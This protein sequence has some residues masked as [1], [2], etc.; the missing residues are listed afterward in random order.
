MKRTYEWKLTDGRTVTLEAE[1]SEHCE[2]EVL[3]LDGDKWN[4]GK[5]IIRKSGMLTVYLDGKK[6][7]SCWDTNF[8]QVI[9]TGKPGIK[10]IWGIKQ[11]AF[12][13]ERAEEIAKFLADAIEAGRDAE[14]QEIRVAENAAEVAEEIENAEK[15][16]AAAE[17]QKDIPDRAEAKRRMKRWNDV[18]N[19]GGEGYV[20]HIICREEYEH[21]K[22]KLEKLRA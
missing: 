2:D 20:P 10:K 22:Q 18:H 19:E 9:E 21:A 12:T 4:T 16:I 17:A 5:R 7:D 13:A 15:L 8:W 14:A 1:Y 3:N 6:F 11:I